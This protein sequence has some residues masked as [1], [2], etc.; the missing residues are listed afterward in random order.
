MGK[1]IEVRHFM[2][3]HL[4]SCTYEIHTQPMTIDFPPKQQKRTNVKLFHLKS[5]KAINV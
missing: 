1:T 2:A 3:S 4:K 5:H